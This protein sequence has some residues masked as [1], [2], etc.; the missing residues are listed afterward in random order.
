MYRNLIIP[1][2][3]SLPSFFFPSSISSLL[4]SI[5]PS[6]PPSRAQSSLVKLHELESLNVELNKKMMDADK[7]KDELAWAKERLNREL[8]K[9]K[10]ELSAVR[11]HLSTAESERA[12][13][14][15]E[16]RAVQQLLIQAKETE[17]CVHLMH[18]GSLCC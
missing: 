10:A 13:A 16:V 17:V 8:E 18:V 9:L 6:L 12:S 2:P 15:G 3:L 11:C 14:M 7:E 1:F 5:P 4:P